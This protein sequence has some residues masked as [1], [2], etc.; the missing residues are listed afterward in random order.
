MK[1]AEIVMKKISVLDFCCDAL[2]QNVCG[3][4]ILFFRKRI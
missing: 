1:K 2:F 3:K 4:K